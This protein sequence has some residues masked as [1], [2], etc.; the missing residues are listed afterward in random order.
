MRKSKN[1]LFKTIL[2]TVHCHLRSGFLLLY[3]LP[4]FYRRK[5]KTSSYLFA[6]VSYGR[7][8]GSQRLE[9]HSDVKKMSSK[10]KVVKVSKNRH[11]HVPG[12]VEEGLSGWNGDKRQGTERVTTA[13]AALIS[14][15]LSLHFLHPLGVTCNVACYMMSYVTCCMMM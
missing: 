9:P 5:R 7:Q 15:F 8:D 11:G 2:K 13:K 6:I 3:L 12:K 1:P 14:L 4:S 10:K